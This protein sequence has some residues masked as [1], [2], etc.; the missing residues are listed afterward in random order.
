MTRS[1]E[2][3]GR[4]RASKGGDAPLLSAWILRGSVVAS[5]CQPLSVGFFFAAF[6]GDVLIPA[7]AYERRQRSSSELVGAVRGA[8]LV[9]AG[10][11]PLV[12]DNSTLLR[13]FSGT[14]VPVL[15]GEDVIH[16]LLV[17][18]ARCARD[19]AASLLH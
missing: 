17:V 16:G 9:C 4:R 5:S 15:Q 13:C 1:R 6:A 18:F 19:G 12:L 7:L 11:A 3:V 14:I 8:G 10:F 2:P